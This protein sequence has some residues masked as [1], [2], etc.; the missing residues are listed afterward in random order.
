MPRDDE[1]TQKLLCAKF[2][3]EKGQVF[4]Q[5]SKDFLDAT[6]ELGDEDASLAMQYLGLAPAP[7][8]AAMVRR[9]DAR[10]RKSYACLLR[11]IAD[12][13]LKAVIRAEAPRHG[14]NAWL[15][16]ER[17]C[18]EST[19]SNTVNAKILE[20]HGLTIAKDVGVHD[21]RQRRPVDI[22]VSV[23]TPQRGQSTAS[24]ETRR[25]C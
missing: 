24:V 4:T 8:S 17:E 13:S 23:H 20:W 19:S 22:N 21:H 6:E 15:I 2:T 16:I 25:V 7:T 1:D 3:G 14:R 18:A 10:N 9:R 11:H 12:E 5:W